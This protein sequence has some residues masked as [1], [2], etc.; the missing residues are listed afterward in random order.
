MMRKIAGLIVLGG[1]LFF[2]N[3]D[4]IDELSPIHPQ[5][6]TLLLYEDFFDTIFPPPG[7][8]RIILVGNYNWERRETPIPGM[9][10]A[11]YPSLSASPG[12][13]ARLIS[14]PIGVGAFPTICTLKFSM[15]HAPEYP[16]A[17]DSLKIEYSTN[18]STFTQ[19]AAF[20]RYGPVSGLVEHSV[21]LGTFSGTMYVGFLGF[22]GYGDDI[23]LDEVR[24]IGN[25]YEPLQNDVGVDSIISP[26]AFHRLNIAMVPIARVKN[27]GTATQY[28]FPVVCSIVGANGTLRYT[29]TQNISLLGPGETI[30][31]NFS[32]W[33]PN[34]LEQCTVKMRT[35]LS[36][37]ENPTNDRKTRT[38]QI[39]TDVLYEGFNNGVPPPGWQA[40]IVQGSANWVGHTAGTYPTCAPYEGNAMAGYS[41]SGTN[42]SKARLIS[43][44]ITFTT[45][46]SCNLKFW[47]CHGWNPVPFPETLKVE[48][49]TDGINFT[50]VA[51][52][53]SSDTQYGWVEHNVHFV[54]LYGTFYIGFLGC[55]GLGNN[56]YID[57]VRLM[58]LSISEEKLNNSPR[59]TMLNPPRPNPITNGLTYLSFTLAEPSQVSLKIFDASGRLVKALVNEFKSAGVYT[60]TWNGRNNTGY[61]VK[62]GIYFYTLITNG[63]SITNKI[64]KAN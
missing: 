55:A 17:P 24:L 7:W 51:Y 23:Y 12:S 14:P 35:N 18:G 53:F 3:A 64:I 54:T 45:P 28:N 19:V 52:F 58:P 10:M 62:S 31:V 47:L 32:T 33:V 38:T 41:T 60:A 59:I 8:Q 15:M 27:Y 4:N 43:P 25:V 40:V 44:P 9:V 57:M 46:M 20:N 16:P 39:Y 22:S 49:S 6:D 11:V 1:M 61:E 42:G 13:M 21:Y 37:D 34:V 56:I 30:L 50:E 5:R 26:Q 63:K 2:L 36:G 29:N 48:Y